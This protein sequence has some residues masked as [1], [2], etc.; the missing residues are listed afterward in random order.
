MKKTEAQKII[1][2]YKPHKVFF[3]ISVKPDGLTDIEYAEI[4]NTQNFIAEQ[5]KNVEYLRNHDRNT[6]D[7]LSELAGKLQIVILK[8]WGD[9]VFV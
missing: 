7:E 3:D 2:Q 6:F 5:N 9:S 8:Y 1:L 4:L